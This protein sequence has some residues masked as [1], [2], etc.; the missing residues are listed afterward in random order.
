[1]VLPCFSLTWMLRILFEAPVSALGV[2]ADKIKAVTAMTP[3][4]MRPFLMCAVHII[5]ISLT[6]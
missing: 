3:L 4:T 6:G 1:M 2:L 5:I